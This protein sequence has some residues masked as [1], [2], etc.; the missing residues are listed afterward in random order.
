[1][2][3][4]LFQ[5]VHRAAVVFCCVVIYLVILD[6]VGKLNQTSK[7]GQRFFST[8]S[9]RNEQ[10]KKKNDSNRQQ[11]PYGKIKSST[12]RIEFDGGKQIMLSHFKNR[13][14]YI[15]RNIEIENFSLVLFHSSVLWMLFLRA[16]LQKI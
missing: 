7:V 9:I 2:F 5:S 8:L 10:R 15:K 16:V 11:N 14:E 3:H 12:E 13:K 6:S 4:A 1:M